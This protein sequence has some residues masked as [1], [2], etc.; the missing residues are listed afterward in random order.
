MMVRGVYFSGGRQA[1]TGEPHRISD[2]Q[3]NQISNRKSDGGIFAFADAMAIKLTNEEAKKLR[4]W[5]SKGKLASEPSLVPGPFAISNMLMKSDRFKELVLKK[6]DRNYVAADM[7]S[8]LIADG[9][10]SLRV[11]PH[12]YAVRAI[13]DPATSEKPEYDAIGRGLIRQWAMSN[14]RQT[15]KTA[16]ARSEAVRSR[17]GFARRG[18]FGSQ[19]GLSF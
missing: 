9:L 16:V 10:V 5:Q 12:F 19:R 13:S 1:R 8:G 2:S 6:S 4:A 15:V 14:A 11:P 7:E 3:F 18:E 17:T